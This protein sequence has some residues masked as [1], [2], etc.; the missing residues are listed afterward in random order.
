M[1]IPVPRWRRSEHVYVGIVGDRYGTMLASGRS[2]THEEFLEAKRR[3][4][5]HIGVGVPR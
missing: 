2:P 4:A 1:R 3:G 5:A